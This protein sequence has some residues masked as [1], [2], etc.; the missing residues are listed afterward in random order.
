MRTSILAAAT[1][2][3]LAA[4]AES[5]EDSAPMLPCTVRPIGDPFVCDV[6][7]VQ[8]IARPE[9][10]DGRRVRVIGFVNFEFEGNGIYI[11]AEDYRQSIYRNGL[12]LEALSSERIDSGSAKGVPNQQYAIVEATFNA[13]NHGHLG[14][15]SGA[16]EKTTRLDSWGVPPDSSNRTGGRAREVGRVEQRADLD[17][18]E[19]AVEASMRH[20]LFPRRDSLPMDACSVLRALRSDSIRTKELGDHLRPQLSGAQRSACVRGVAPFSGAE[21]VYLDSVITSVSGQGGYATVYLTVRHTSV[22]YREK[23]F[24]SRSIAAGRVRVTGVARWIVDSV[25][26]GPTGHHG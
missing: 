1:V 4:C 8:L 12:W 22:F 14:M 3:A 10:F 9:T 2:L 13:R 11:S 24:L 17:A 6:S 7:L 23:Y 16:L 26:T 20:R 25:M 5:E 15:W 19:M 21:A 18:A